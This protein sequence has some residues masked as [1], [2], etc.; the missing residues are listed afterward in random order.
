MAANVWV[1]QSGQQGSN[2]NGQYDQPQWN[3]MTSDVIYKGQR[4]E[5]VW[6][7]GK[8]IWN[9]K[10]T[11]WKFAQ[12]SLLGGHAFRS[13]EYYTNSYLPTMRNNKYIKDTYGPLTASFIPGA[14][15]HTAPGI[16]TF[17]DYDEIYKDHDRY[18]YRLY[19]PYIRPGEYSASLI[20]T[21][22]DESG[23]FAT[24]KFVTSGNKA[25]PET[26]VDQ[27]DGYGFAFQ[28]FEIQETGFPFGVIE[29]RGILPPG[30]YSLS[31]NIPAGLKQSYGQRIAPYYRSYYFGSINGMV[32][33]AYSTSD[34]IGLAS[35]YDLYHD[36]GLELGTAGIFSRPVYSFTLEQS[37]EVV[38]QVEVCASDGNQTITWSPMLTR[39]SAP[40][41][42]ALEVRAGQLR[43]IFSTKRDRT[44]HEFLYIVNDKRAEYSL[45]GGIYELSIA[46]TKYLDPESLEYV[47]ATCTSASARSYTFNTGVTVS[48][49]DDN[50]RIRKNGKNYDMY[51]VLGFSWYGGM[52][53]AE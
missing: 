11:F 40:S 28:W 50:V 48:F 42:P 10:V 38:I 51:Y 5:E 19:P 20:C 49:L 26:I 8:C 29:V 43:G 17:F 52:L 32:F 45:S 25:D 27:I 15:I 46:P 13:P 18:K 24:F 2:D 47:E 36:E 37:S 22:I 9:G 53:D 33:A 39:S 21:Q 16:E 44:G 30:K 14:F 7:K 23:D 41:T 34:F 1:H 3:S 6:Y 12:F 4:A 31:S 35:A